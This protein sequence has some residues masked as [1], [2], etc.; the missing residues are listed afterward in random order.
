VPDHNYII[1]LKNAIAK[2]GFVHFGLGVTIV[3][4][5]RGAMER[6]GTRPCRMFKVASARGSHSRPELPIP[7]VVR[8]RPRAPQLFAKWLRAEEPRLAIVNGNAH[9]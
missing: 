3:A 4:T 8:M 9:G 2:M 6:G 1:H 5:A 7:V